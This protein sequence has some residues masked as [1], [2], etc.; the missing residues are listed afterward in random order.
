MN[1]GTSRR[2]SRRW[3]RPASCV[4]LMVAAASEVWTQRG[5]LVRR[6]PQVAAAAPPL[7]VPRAPLGD[8]PWMLDTAEQHK[9]K[10]SIVA[11]GLVNPWSLAWLPD[12]SM[13]ITERPGPAAA[14]QERRARPDADQPACR[15]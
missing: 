7:G 9:I 12:G 10:V 11:S 6:P 8:G 13:L 3:S 5:A 14:A 2:S 4:A 1:A 15:W